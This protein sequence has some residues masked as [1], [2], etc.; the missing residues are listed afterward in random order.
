LKEVLAAEGL[1]KR[2]GATEALRGVTFA[3]EGPQVVG[4]LGPNGAGK[5]TLLEILEGISPPGGG[6]VR[7]FGADLSLTAS[8]WRRSIYPRRRVGVVL[9]REFALD[10]ITAGDY[11][12]LFAAIQG[13]RGGE[14]RILR[15][16]GLEAR[17]SVPV[18]RLSGGEAQRLFIAAA[19]VHDPDLVFLDE[20]TAQ[21]DPENKA[22]VGELMR[23]LGRTRTVVVTTHDL[24]EADAVC[25]HVIFLVGGRIEAQGPRDALLAA[26]PEEKRKGHGLEDA[27]FHFC[28]ARLDERG[29]LGEPR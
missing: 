22:R 13:V 6:S 4:I 28:S 14:G 18:E 20:P 29:V 17:R 11:A 7:L 12:E 15:A 1:S 8:G 27:F 26:V 25:D 3:V 23:S 5:T 9:Q 24:R 10:A 16:A 21:L 19:V 2:F